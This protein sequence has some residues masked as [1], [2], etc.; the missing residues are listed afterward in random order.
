M[1]RSLAKSG[2]AVA[3]KSLNEKWLIIVQSTSEKG[4]NEIGGFSTVTLPPSLFRDSNSNIPLVSH[5]GGGS[6]GCGCGWVTGAHMTE[7][8]TNGTGAHV[9][10]V[11]GMSR[12]GQLT[13]GADVFRTL[14]MN[15]VGRSTLE[16]SYHGRCGR[17]GVGDI[18]GVGTGASDSH[19][20]FQSSGQ[21][22]ASR[23]HR[24]SSSSVNSRSTSLSWS[25]VSPVMLLR[26]KRV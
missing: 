24:Q 18:N 14:G 9:A 2:K 16:A 17:G 10:G 1:S 12:S 26:G 8:S 7:L 21:S 20:H 19:N 25:S 15:V 3:T 6:T 11:L 13:K 22:N 4:E 5:S 23:A